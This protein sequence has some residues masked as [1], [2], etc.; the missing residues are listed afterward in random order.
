MSLIETTPGTADRPPSP[1]RAKVTSALLRRL[2]LIPTAVATAGALLIAA[3]AV[4]SNSE[5]FDGHAIAHWGIAVPTLF[6]S[7]VTTRL[8]D[9]RTA[10]R[11][12]ARLFPI[13][14]L[15][16]LAVSQ[17]LEGVGAFASSF[18]GGLEE[19]LELAH[20]LGEGGTLLAIFVL[21]LGVIVLVLVYVAAAI[22][23][24]RNRRPEANA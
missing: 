22:R 6:L 20:G 9:A 2:L 12:I 10:P 4:L 18:A 11:R 8:P 24:L 14:A 17:I 19:S 3:F 1:A 21:P 15:M 13:V 23:S 16:G 7:L 5:N